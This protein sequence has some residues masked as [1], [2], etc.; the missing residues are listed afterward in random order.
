M[1]PI[2]FG[3]VHVIFTS[4]NIYFIQSVSQSVIERKEE[5]EWVALII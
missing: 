3:M 1:L 2:T 5:E 4:I